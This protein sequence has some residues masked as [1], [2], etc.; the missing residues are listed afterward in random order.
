MF[1]PDKTNGYRVA[2]H[3]DEVNHCPGCGG[4]QWLVGR[5]VAECAFCAAAVSLAS[6]GMTGA[7]LFRANHVTPD[8][9]AA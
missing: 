2:F 3:A 9:L 5:L 8:S 7:G 6:A 1:R 4:T